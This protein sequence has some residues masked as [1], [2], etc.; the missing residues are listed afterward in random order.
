MG[1]IDIKGPRRVYADM[2]I[3]IGVGIVGAVRDIRGRPIRGCPT[4]IQCEYAPERGDPFFF[5]LLSRRRRRQCQ[6]APAGIR[7]D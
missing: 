3:R 6:C 2:R 4:V 5:H 7:M 1:R